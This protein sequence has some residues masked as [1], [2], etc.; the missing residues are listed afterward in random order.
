MDMQLQLLLLLIPWL[1]IK[2]WPAKVFSTGFTL[3]DVLMNWLNWFHFLILEEGVLVILIDCMIFRCYKDA[4]VNSFF[5]H[6]D[7]LRN[8][9][10]VECFLLTF[11]INGLSLESRDTY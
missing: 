6:T 2:M 3:V 10:P 11:G 8:S 7:R 1:I 4:Y 9:L 5:P